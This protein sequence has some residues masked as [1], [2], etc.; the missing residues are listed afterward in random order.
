MQTILLTVAFL[1][2][3]MAFSMALCGSVL[4]SAA[5]LWGLATLT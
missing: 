2:V 3:A 1:R 4:A 5:I